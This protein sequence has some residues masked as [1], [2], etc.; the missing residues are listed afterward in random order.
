MLQLSEAGKKEG[1]EEGAVEMRGSVRARDVE[2]G[3]GAME[4]SD[5]ESE[6]EEKPPPAGA[7]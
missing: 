6:G 5:E 3:L 1:E 2:E 7:W 4:W